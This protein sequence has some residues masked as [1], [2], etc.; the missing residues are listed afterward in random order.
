MLT[1]VCT[2][3]QGDRL[4]EGCPKTLLEFFSEARH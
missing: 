1:A 3:L 4:S 2:E